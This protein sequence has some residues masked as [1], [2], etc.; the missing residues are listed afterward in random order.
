MPLQT[1]LQ[2]HEGVAVDAL[3]AEMPVEQRQHLPHCLF[4]AGFAL[5]DSFDELVL[6]A[7]AVGQ[8]VHQDF[9]VR[10]AGLERLG[11]GGSNI[12]A[13]IIADA[14][15]RKAGYAGGKRTN[16]PVGMRLQFP[17]LP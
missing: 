7:L 8:F 13:L 5:H 11:S 1:R 14:G 2:R 10:P 6:G 9:K 3:A 16:C 4:V 15:W 17:A 12:H